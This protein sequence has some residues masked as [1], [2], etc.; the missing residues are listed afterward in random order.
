MITTECANCGIV[1]D[2]HDD[3][4]AYVCNNDELCHLRCERRD[5]HLVLTKAG[6]IGADE[7]LWIGTRIDMLVHQ[8]DKARTELEQARRSHSID[9]GAA[10]HLGG[11]PMRTGGDE[12]LCS[13]I[14]SPRI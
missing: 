10:V 11:C 8:L 14:L 7:S 2:C 13:E 3:G 5:A 4:E 1:S 9:F 6:I 12:C